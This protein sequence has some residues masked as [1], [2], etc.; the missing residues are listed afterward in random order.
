MNGRII[1]VSRKLF[2]VDGMQRLDAFK[3]FGFDVLRKVGVHVFQIVL[4]VCSCS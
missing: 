4:T 1:L 3:E 2:G